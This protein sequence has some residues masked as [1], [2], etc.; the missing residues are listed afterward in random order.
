MLAIVRAIERFHIYLYGLDFIVKTDCNALVHAMNKANINP[1][2]ARWTLALQNYKFRVEHRPGKNM[3]HV[4][5]LS[6]HVIYVDEMPIEKQLEYRQLQDDR[7]KEIAAEL[8]QDNNDK[9]KLIDGLVYKKSEEGLRFCIPELM[10]QQIIRI[11]HDEMAHCGKEKT[12]EGIKRIYWFPSMK[13][14]VDQYVDN[15]IT[16]LMA[17]A[18]VNSREGELQIERY[19]NLPFEIIHVDHFGPLPETADGYKY[20]L[21]VIDAF[22]RYT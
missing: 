9:F 22:T 12:I 15:C 4:D 16:C 5:A 14:K 18:S 10:I 2:I 6:R 8:E 7:L 19:P 11:H 1:R 3:A 20:I 17:N 21:V 13:R